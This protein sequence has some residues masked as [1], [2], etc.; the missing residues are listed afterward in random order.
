MYGV[1]VCMCVCVY[2]CVSVCMCLCVCVWCVCVYV[3]VSVC[4]T[5]SQLSYVIMITP[6]FLWEKLNW[7]Q[8]QLNVYCF[9]L[10]DNIQQ[11]TLLQLCSFINQRMEGFPPLFENDSV[12]IDYP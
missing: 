4:V 1:C 5:S 11:L 9:D 8:L 7:S 3:C 2:V 6:V 12:I 10:H